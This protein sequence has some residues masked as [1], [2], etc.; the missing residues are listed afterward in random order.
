[1]N[2]I[3]YFS[4]TNTL[5]Q[6]R[7]LDGAVARTGEAPRRRSPKGLLCLALGVC[8]VAEKKNFR[9]YQGRG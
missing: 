8:D 4:Y 2:K 5:I 3:F 1:M 6:Y 9:T 7:R